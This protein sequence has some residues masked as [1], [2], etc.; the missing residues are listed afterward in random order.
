MTRQSTRGST[1]LSCKLTQ[2]LYYQVT[3]F[4][5]NIMPFH[6]DGWTKIDDTLHATHL[7]AFSQAKILQSRAKPEKCVYLYSNLRE[8]DSEES[9][10]KK[11]RICPRNGLVPNWLQVITWNSDDPVHLRIIVMTSSNGNIFR[12]TG[13]LCGEFTGHRWIPLTKASDAGLW[14]FLWSASE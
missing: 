9:N 2:H 1:L 14:C 8:V 10:C 11:V 7:N 3:V 4:R 5:N 12:V 6:I 13:H